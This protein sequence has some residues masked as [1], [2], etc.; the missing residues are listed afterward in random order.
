MPEQSHD[1]GALFEFEL[2]RRSDAEIWIKHRGTG[3]V[4][5]FKVLDDRYGLRSEHTIVPNPTSTIDAPMFSTPA[6]NAALRYLTAGSD[7]GLADGRESR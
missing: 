1:A 5:Q 7:S 4:Y 2:D 6:R 3:H